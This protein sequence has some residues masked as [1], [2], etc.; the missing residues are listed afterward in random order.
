MNHRKFG[1]SFLACVL[2]CLFAGAAHADAVTI[3][4]NELPNDTPINGINLSGVNFGFTV[5]GAASTDARF[6]QIGPRNGAFVQCPCLEGNA[7][8][9]LTLNFAAPTSVLSFGVARVTDLNLSPGA[10]VQLFDAG[11]LLIGTY[12]VNLV[13]APSLNFPEGLFSYTGAGV[14]RAI[15]TFNN[16]PAALRFALDNVTFDRPAAVP[17]PATLVLL[18]TGL[19]GIAG[20][21]R[22]KRS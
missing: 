7:A 5:N 18:G 3:R 9:T 13:R 6:R 12:T 21:R 1:L 14:S 4:F 2:I 10:T 16:P 8:G 20:V 15:V 19:A 17:E 11:S 22:R